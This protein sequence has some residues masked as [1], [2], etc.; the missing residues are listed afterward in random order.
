MSSTKNDKKRSSSTTD[1]PNK[2]TKA[3]V[4]P[5][6][7]KNNQIRCQFCR[8]PKDEADNDI[9]DGDSTDIVDELA[10]LTDSKLVNPMAED[11][12][13]LL[14]QRPQMRLTDFSIYDKVRSSVF[15]S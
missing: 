1:Q 2:K 15:L 7:D 9:Y 4:T 5:S 8:R 14:D 12:D 11:S 13:N 6:D 3:T 10:A